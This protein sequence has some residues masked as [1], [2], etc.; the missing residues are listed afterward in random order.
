MS[1]PVTRDNIH[2]SRLIPLQF[3]DA[4][5]S[6]APSPLNCTDPKILEFLQAAT[7]P[8]TRRAYQSDLRH[9]LAHGGTI[10]ATA[11]QI[12]RYLV[13]HAAVL[14]MAT[15]ARR[16]VSIRV[17]HLGRGFPDPT[18]S[19]L[20]RLIFRGVRRK[21]GQP[22]RRVRA[23]THSDLSA[24]I[25]SLGQSAKDIR[26]AAILLVGFAGAFRRSELAAMDYQQIEIG[27]DCAA[28]QIPRSK[29][30]QEGH[31]RTIRITRTPGALCPIAALQ[32]WL[33]EACITEGPVFRPL[34]KNGKLR[35]RRISPGAIASILKHRV[36][37]IGRNPNCYS[38]HSLRAGFAT[39]AA[40][41]GVPKWR[42]KGQTGHLSDSAVERYIREGELHSSHAPNV[43]TAFAARDASNES[44]APNVPRQGSKEP[45]GLHYSY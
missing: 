10:P 31:G 35:K 28:I 38:G 24:I 22:Q 9:F 5:V 13:D 41:L 30:D 29:T 40:R 43:L 1:E 32:A 39:E 34:M 42:I 21:H 36:S 23:L 17:T 6:D 15:L 33:L 7:A 26:D 14:S 27:N 37:E 11:E 2:L 12:A 19:E 20:V 4:A 45:R 18:R 25:P 16:L 8:S 3:G 44:N